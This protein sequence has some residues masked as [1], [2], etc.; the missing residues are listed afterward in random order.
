MIINNY[1]VGKTTTNLL[2]NSVI[3]IGEVSNENSKSYLFEPRL[4]EKNINS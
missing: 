3:I 1:D 4:F 2:K